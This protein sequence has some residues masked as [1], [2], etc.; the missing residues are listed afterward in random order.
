MGW[1]R[2]LFLGDLGQQMDIGDLREDVGQLRRELTRA[3]GNAPANTADARQ[4]LAIRRLQHENDDLRLCVT[5][6]TRAMVRKGV[7]TADE[8]KV[9]AE[10]LD[11]SPET[12]QG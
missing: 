8:A 9:L 4:D 1:S 12:G 11:P 2:Y 7:L 5:V 10:N 6:L 3:R